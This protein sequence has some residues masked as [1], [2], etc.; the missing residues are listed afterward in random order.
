MTNPHSGTG[1]RL[2]ERGGGLTHDTPANETVGTGRGGEGRVD[3][4]EGK[5]RLEMESVSERE[6]RG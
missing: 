5:S 1:Q 2:W 4:C 6:I 3:G